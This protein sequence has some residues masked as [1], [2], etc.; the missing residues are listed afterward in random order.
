MSKENVERLRNLIEAWER[1]DFDTALSFYDE[2][3][4]WESGT[5]PEGARI[6]RGPAGVARA[7]EE[8]IGAFTEYWG[9]ID[10]YLDAGDQ[11][12]LLF[13]EGGKGRSSGVP[14]EREV[15]SVFTFR[16]GKIVRVQ[17]GLHRDE[18]LQAAGLSE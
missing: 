2:G 16:E 5:A 10:D 7:V 6:Y 11:V 4:T 18:A 1:G 14:V 3:A 8:W 13:R 15:G 17:A 12:V 9:Q